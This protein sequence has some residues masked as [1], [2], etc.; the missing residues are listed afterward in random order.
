MANDIS[1]NSDSSYMA[2]KGVVSRRN[3][4]GTIVL[5]RV[6]DAQ[7]FYKID[8]LAAAIWSELETPKRTSSLV[9]HFTALFPEQAEALQTEIPN[10]MNQLLSKELVFE[11]QGEDTPFRT[12]TFLKEE[13]E[14]NF[15]F[16][17]LKEFD[18]EQIETEVLNE[19]VYLDVFAGSDLRI[20]KEI[21]SIEG[22]LEKVSQ[23]NGVTYKWNQDQVP[24]ADAFTHAGLIAQDV[25]AVMPELVRKDKDSGIMAVDYAK[26]NSYLV[27]AIK[28]LN[29]L[30]LRQEA[31]IQELEKRVSPSVN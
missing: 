28:D 2:T 9:S 26:L 18:L 23:L 6:D 27:E 5:M 3:Q 13:L 19:S 30:V 21:Q 7:F 12:E 20:K 11:K 14:K 17:E 25:A 8:G 10:F 22:A 4:D 29:Q 24:Q 1:V 31:R 15:T 16:G